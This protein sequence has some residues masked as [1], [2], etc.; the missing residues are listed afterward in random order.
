MTNIRLST[1]AERRVKINEVIK[2]AA[3]K[4]IDAL[5]AIQERER[6]LEE[7]GMNEV[8]EKILSTLSPEERKNPNV[9][10]LLYP[11]DLH[12]VIDYGRKVNKYEREIRIYLQD[13]S[14]N[15]QDKIDYLQKNRLEIREQI[16]KSKI[17]QEILT[18]EDGLFFL[19]LF[20]KTP[21]LIVEVNN[22]VY[23]FEESET[24]VIVDLLAK[25][26]AYSTILQDYQPKLSDNPDLKEIARSAKHYN[27][28]VEILEE[29]N[30]LNRESMKLQNLQGPMTFTAN[31]LWQLYYQDMF[32]R[33][34]ILTPLIVMEVGNKLLYEKMKDRTSKK[35]TAST[36]KSAERLEKIVKLIVGRSKA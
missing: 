11:V 29:E 30:L 15:E 6:D 8:W 10:E 32:K 21:G 13:D 35:R 31:L 26:Q 5:E 9:L 3:A 28:I 23:D 34:L 22:N 14:Y 18:N 25:Y 17:G 7:A 24:K 20:N 1:R 4:P 33:N 27:A 2:T 36:T 19:Q 16:I 12:E